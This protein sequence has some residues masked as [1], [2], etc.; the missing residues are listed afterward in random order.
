[1]YLE[2]EELY[3]MKTIQSKFNEELLLEQLLDSPHI[4][5]QITKIKKGNYFSKDQASQ[6]NVYFLIKGI[7][8]LHYNERLVVIAD[9]KDFIGLDDLLT[10]EAPTYN[11]EA[12]EECEVIIFNRHEIMD[13]LFSTQ[14]G[15]LYL[16]LNEKKH[17][18]TLIEKIQFL[19]E[20]GIDR[21]ANTYCD[22][23][24][25]FGEP[26]KDGST[27]PKCF[28]LRR[29]AEIA[30]ISSNSVASFNEILKERGL[31][32]KKQTNCIVVVAPKK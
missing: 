11:V 8:G 1:M 12:L 31:I 19:R 22:L 21:L 30:N 24:T 3:N 15:W 6:D 26:T 28:N 25:R 16:Y 5:S 20:K 32:I 4:T 13:F 17:H 10:K 2:L 27:L 9:Q 7:A 18:E 29:L 23:A 14:E